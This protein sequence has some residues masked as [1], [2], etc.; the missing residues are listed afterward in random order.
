MLFFDCPCPMWYAEI[1][2]YRSHLLVLLLV[3]QAPKWLRNRGDTNKSTNN[4]P[5]RP[6]HKAIKA[7]Q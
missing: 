5:N 3:S 7:K 1:C 6:C 2:W 4:A